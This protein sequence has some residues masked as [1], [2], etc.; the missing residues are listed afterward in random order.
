MDIVALKKSVAVF[1]SELNTF[2][3][4]SGTPVPM[5]STCG[6]LPSGRHSR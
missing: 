4:S 5:V 2:D 3:L 1:L 6:G